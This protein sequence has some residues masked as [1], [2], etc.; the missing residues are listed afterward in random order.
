M[1]PLGCVPCRSSSP[2]R[3]PLPPLRGARRRRARTPPPRARRGDAA[4]QEPLSLNKPAE[5]DILSAARD[6]VG[7]LR[8]RW[9][10]PAGDGWTLTATL[11]ATPSADT[12]AAVNPVEIPVGRWRRFRHNQY[13]WWNPQPLLQLSLSAEKQVAE[14][15]AAES[16]TPQLQSELPA[17]DIVEAITVHTRLLLITRHQI[18][19]LEP[20]GGREPWSSAQQAPARA[21]PARTVPVAGLELLALWSAY[22]A[23]ALRKKSGLTLTDFN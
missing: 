23:P 2:P 14:F 21:A 6:L 7:N 22:R 9:R 11:P 16:E 18:D 19:S 17:A 12:P 15:A 1:E 20:A 4:P 13:V 10:L 8:L 5:V 3:H